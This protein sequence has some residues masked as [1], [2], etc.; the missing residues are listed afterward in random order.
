M[1]AAYQRQVIEIE[2]YMYIEWLDMLM[3]T[4]N[5]ID[6]PSLS[7]FLMMRRIADRNKLMLALK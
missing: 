5:A 6:K 4:L 2:T 7:M 3:T 1:E